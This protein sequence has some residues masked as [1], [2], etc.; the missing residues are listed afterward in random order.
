MAKK[1]LKK[2]FCTLLIYNRV[3][4]KNQNILEF[5]QRCTFS[6]RSQNI[7]QIFSTMPMESDT[8][9]SNLVWLAWIRPN[10]LMFDWKYHFLQALERKC[11][12]CLLIRKS[13]CISGEIRGFF[14]FLDLLYSISHGTNWVS[15]LYLL[16][17]KIT[18]PYNQF[19]N[20]NFDKNACYSKTH[21][22]YFICGS[23]E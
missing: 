22:I 18:A 13:M 17:S 1:K 5:N 20:I 11:K 19:D 4:L 23:F 9:F 8:P 15:Y 12:T 3:S 21:C 10:G 14:G 2:Y 7:F 16:T 6:P